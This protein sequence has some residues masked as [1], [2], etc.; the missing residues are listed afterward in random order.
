MNI[1]ILYQII[2]EQQVI[3]KLLG[4][5]LKLLEKNETTKSDKPDLATDD[6]SED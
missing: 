6:S 2:G 3:I 1:N 5:K 4:E